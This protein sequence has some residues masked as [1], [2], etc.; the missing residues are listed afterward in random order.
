MF[1]IQPIL[2]VLRLHVSAFQ[3]YMGFSGSKNFG[4][5]KGKNNAL[6]AITWD[7]LLILE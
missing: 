2:F 4:H 6:T 3:N 5:F 1:K 7:F